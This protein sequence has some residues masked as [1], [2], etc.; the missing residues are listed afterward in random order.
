MDENRS[1]ETWWRC[2]YAAYL[3]SELRIERMD[4]TEARRRA[5]TSLRDTVEGFL[6]GKWN[7]RNAEIPYGPGLGGE[8]TR[9]PAPDGVLDPH[10]SRAGVPLDDLTLD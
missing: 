5:A 3:G 6:E 2:A 10:Q 9:L 7:F 1:E 4:E 8:R